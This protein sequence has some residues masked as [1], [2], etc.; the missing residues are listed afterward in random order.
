MQV[1]EHE[2]YAWFLFKEGDALILDVNCNHGA[3]GYGVMIRLSA[4]EESEYSREGH[5]YLNRLAEAVQDSGPGRGY[6]L[7]DVSAVYAKESRSVVNE[8]RASAD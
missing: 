4:E 5:S 8:W 1:V 6:Q 7:R 2:P 3:V